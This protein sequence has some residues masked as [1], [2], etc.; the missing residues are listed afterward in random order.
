MRPAR[1]EGRS[2]SGF[3]QRPGAAPV[4]SVAK[5]LATKVLAYYFACAERVIARRRPLKGKSSFSQRA[6]SRKGAG[7]WKLEMNSRG[8]SFP[9]SVCRSRVTKMPSHSW[10]C[11]HNGHIAGSIAPIPR[12]GS[13]K[14]RG[15]KNEGSS[16]YIHDNK[17]T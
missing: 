13:E 17:P 11:R 6:Q 5:N 4:R 8:A 2:P 15:P 1:E 14:K 16:G 3:S 10:R 9:F 12:K 7:N